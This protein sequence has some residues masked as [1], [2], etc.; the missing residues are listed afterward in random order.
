MG[1]VCSLA[2]SPSSDGDSSFADA[3]LE[4]VKALP[5]EPQPLVRGLNYSHD[6]MIDLI[7]ANPGIH[8]NA[9]ARVMGYSASW[10]STIMATDAF[11]AKL[12]ERREEIV[13]PV[14][15]A[16][17]EEQAR[18]LFLR[19][20]EILREKLAGDSDTVPDQLAL[21][22]FRDSAKVLG[23]GARPPEPPSKESV[24][25]SLVK[26]ADNLVALLRKERKIAEGDVIDVGPSS[27]QI[28]AT[29]E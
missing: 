15:K 22:T 27:P 25:E 28:T 21:Q 8:Q 14:L 16:T 6:Q 19:S 3:L 11:Q 7:V 4:E 17:M 5:S 12:A 29:P 9:I 20:M 13:D 1:E 10:V 26:H 2:P 18:G 23:Y 24:A